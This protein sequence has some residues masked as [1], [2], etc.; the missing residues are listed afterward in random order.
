MV[1][2]SIFQPE[3]LLLISLTLGLPAYFFVKYFRTKDT[4]W[5]VFGTVT[6]GVMLFIIACIVYLIGQ[7]MHQ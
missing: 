5:A 2:L 4:R 7:Q 6:L 1:L 3:H